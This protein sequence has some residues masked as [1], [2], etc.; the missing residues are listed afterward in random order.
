MS[1]KSTITFFIDN[2]KGFNLSIIIKSFAFT[3]CFAFALENTIALNYYA[4]H[5]LILN[6]LKSVTWFFYFQNLCKYIKKIGE[7]LFESTKRD[8]VEKFRIYLELSKRIIQ[9]DTSRIDNLVSQFNLTHLLTSQKFQ[10][11]P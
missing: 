3:F 9:L 11:N 7:F 6:R 1:Y 8:I 2:N 4:H 10:P 5:F